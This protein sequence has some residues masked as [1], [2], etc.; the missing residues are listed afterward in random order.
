VSRGA[1]SHVNSVR[2]SRL[3]VGRPV[4][5]LPRVTR[6]RPFGPLAALV[7]GA[8][9][10]GCDAG[11]ASTPP[12][13]AGTPEHPR[14]VVLLLKDYEFI[15]ATIDLVP[16]ET[17]VF[18]VVDGGLV[19]HEAVLGPMSV[20]DA[21]EA[22][23]APTVSAPPGPTAQVSVAPGLEGLRIVVGSGERRDVVWTVPVDIGRGV[24]AWL[25]GCHIPGH[26]AKG[27]VASIRLVGPGG[28]PLSGGPSSTVPETAPAPS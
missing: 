14:P 1:V 23:E 4:P 16:G 3:R 26:W 6:A 20:Q 27:M 5:R 15:P 11:P 2:A 9:L 10:S 13:V 12:I 7:L 22:A 19:T 8:A 28:E 24:G 18:Q 17:V 21:W 25:F